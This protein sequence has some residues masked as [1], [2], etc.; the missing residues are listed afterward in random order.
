MVEREFY[1]ERESIGIAMVAELAAAPLAPVAPVGHS[2]DGGEFTLPCAWGAEEEQ[3]ECSCRE[4]IHLWCFASAEGELE[5]GLGN[6]YP[7][8]AACLSLPFHWQTPLE[9]WF[10][11]R[12]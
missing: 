8:K 3:G 2:E 5:N 10:P 11:P 9:Q 6:L 7:S 1:L 4:E 12:Q